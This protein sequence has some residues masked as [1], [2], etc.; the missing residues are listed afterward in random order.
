MSSP[1]LRDGTCDE[2]AADLAFTVNS[3]GGLAREVV[4]RG[5]RA[6]ARARR[7]LTALLGAALVGLTGIAYLLACDVDSDKTLSDF[8]ISHIRSRRP[9]ASGL[10]IVIVAVF[11]C[12]WPTVGLHPPLGVSV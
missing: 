8:C 2:I 5:V 10:V 11:V 3:S 12:C 1:S 7:R 4:D 9:A 6:A